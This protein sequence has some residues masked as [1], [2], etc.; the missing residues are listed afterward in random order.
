MENIAMAENSQNNPS[1]PNRSWQVGAN[2]ST[3]KNEI[4]LHCIIME[5][6]MPLALDGSSSPKS[7]K[8]TAIYPVLYPA[9]YIKR[10]ITGTHFTAGFELRNST[11][12]AY[13]LRWTVIP[14]MADPINTKMPDP[15]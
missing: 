1:S 14:K 10:A 11:K 6:L 15:M 4:V 2:L 5:L 12:K 3:R 13:F 7:I 8:H 9:K